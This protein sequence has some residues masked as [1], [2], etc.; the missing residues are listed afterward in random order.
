MKALHNRG[1][2]RDYE[3]RRTDMCMFFLSS[4][5]EWPL[6]SNVREL[7]PARCAHQH[8][9][10]EEISYH[11]R[12]NYTYSFHRWGQEGPMCPQTGTETLESP[13]RRNQNCIRRQW[14]LRVCTRS[15]AQSFFHSRSLV[16]CSRLLEVKST[17]HRWGHEAHPGCGGTL[18]GGSTCC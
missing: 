11:H 15:P 8:S 9:G 6:Y 5:G 17:R 10:S 1:L 4:P 18:T 12:L 14:C 3:D 16:F 7:H 13:S 2:N